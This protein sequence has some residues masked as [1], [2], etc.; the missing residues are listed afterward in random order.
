MFTVKET[1]NILN[2]GRTKA[3]ELVRAKEIP[4][5]RLGNSIRVPRE[6]LE[7]CLEEKTEFPK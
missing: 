4:S 6:A 1:A 3:Y 2:I 5:I 7:R